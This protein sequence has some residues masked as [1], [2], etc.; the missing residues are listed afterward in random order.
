V[1]A[2]APR[3]QLLLPASLAWS[4]LLLGVLEWTAGANRPAPLLA[5]A[6]PYVG[7][8]GFG[9]LAVHGILCDDERRRV[10]VL[11]AGVALEILRFVFLAWRLIPLD[12]VVF[13]VGYGFLAAALID[14][15]I[16]HAWRPAALAALVPVGMAGSRLGLADIVQ[17]LT[18]LTYDGTLLALDAT[19][20]VPFSRVAGHF[21]E[22]VPSVRMISLIAYAALP[23]A[24]AAGLAYEEYARR[25]GLARGV[26]VNMLLAY[27]VS[28]TIAALLYVLCPATGPSHAFATGFPGALPDPS[29]VPLQLAVFAP[30]SARNAMPSL[31]V[32]WAALLARSAAGSRRSVRIAAYIFAALTAL[33]TMGSGEHYIFDLIAVAPFL[34]ALEAAT[35]HWSI[36][37][38]ERVPALISGIALYALLMIVIRNGSVAVPHLARSPSLAWAFALLTMGIP[39]ACALRPVHVPGDETIHGG[40][41]TATTTRDL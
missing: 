26:G 35:A 41:A 1:S 7:P 29:S 33:A 15:L 31:H 32:T 19:L 39:I 4:V 17:R 5:L 20:R 22:A 38:R 30:D 21:F 23:G 8:A 34:V 36:S 2:T 27:M 40:P 12:A 18:P 16:H 25:L 24:I 13:S 11:R 28:G 6:D 9:A 3:R 10:L 37:W 14:F